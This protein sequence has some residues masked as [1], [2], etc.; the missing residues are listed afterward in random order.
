MSNS[1]RTRK[2]RVSVE[3]QLGAIITQSEYCFFSLIINNCITQPHKNR[4]PHCIQIIGRLTIDKSN[5]QIEAIQQIF[6]VCPTKERNTN[7][8]HIQY[9]FASVALIFGKNHNKNNSNLIYTLLPEYYSN[10]ICH[11]SDSMLYTRICNKSN[12]RGNVI[13]LAYKKPI[14]D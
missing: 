3:S 5:N 1:Y 7:Q 14:S 6:I 2:N 12:Y 9:V 13:I 8:F 11:V 4:L 10:P